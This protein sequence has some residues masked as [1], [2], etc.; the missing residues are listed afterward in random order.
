M[1]SEAFRNRLVGQVDITEADIS[2]DQLRSEGLRRWNTDMDIE[3]QYETFNGLPVFY[4]GDRYDSVNTEEFIPNAPNE[5]EF[6]TCTQRR[7]DDEDNRSL[8]T[9]M[10]D[11]MCATVSKGVQEQLMSPV[12]YRERVRWKTAGL[13]RTC[14]TIWTIRCGGMDCVWSII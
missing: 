14:G 12:T 10:S 9:V 6:M 7:L 11:P 1:L 2:M 4:G 8:N 3:C 5:M 13:I